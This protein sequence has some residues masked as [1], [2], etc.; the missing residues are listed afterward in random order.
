MTAAARRMIFWLRVTEALPGFL[1]FSSI[2][3]EF[4]GRVGAAQGESAG[5]GS[6]AWSLG[7]LG[8][9]RLSRA[10]VDRRP[11]KAKNETFCF[12]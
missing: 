10:A 3:D 6:A 7:H 2:A 12:V 11:I 1:R 5:Y 4:V 9:V 8:Q